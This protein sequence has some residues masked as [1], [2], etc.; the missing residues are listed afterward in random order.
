MAGGGGG[1]EINKC[2]E[3]ATAESTVMLAAL[4]DVVAAADGRRRIRE[5]TA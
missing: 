3:A 2:L 1:A 5:G 4:V